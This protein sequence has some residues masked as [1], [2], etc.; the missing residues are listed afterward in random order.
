MANHVASLFTK[1]TVSHILLNCLYP[2]AVLISPSVSSHPFSKQ[3]EP[4]ILAEFSPNWGPGVL[5]PTVVLWLG[6]DGYSSWGTNHWRQK[7]NITLS[8]KHGRESG[9]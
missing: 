4:R 8:E 5:L 6:A 7:E 3:Q 2:S 1:N 9:L